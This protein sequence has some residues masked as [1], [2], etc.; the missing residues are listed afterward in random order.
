MAS[1]ALPDNSLSS[2]LLLYLCVATF[3]LL[4]CSLYT[5]L[6]Y[7][8]SLLKKSSYS[9]L[10]SKTLKIFANPCFVIYVNFVQKIQ[11]KT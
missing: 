11:Y 6:T 9:L 3:I 4:L 5:L 7:E 10:I 1:P 2:S 8:A